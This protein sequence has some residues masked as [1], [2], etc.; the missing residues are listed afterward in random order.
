MVLNCRRH[1]SKRGLITQIARFRSTGYLNAND[2]T[3]E[4][5]LES[6]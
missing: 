5:D 6:V 2:C 1:E 3:P 4:I